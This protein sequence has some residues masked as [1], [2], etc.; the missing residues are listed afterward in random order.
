[1]STI[2][3]FGDSITWGAYDLE[4]GGWVARLKLYFDQKG[5]ET[6]IYN[7]G[8]SGN[9][10]KDVLKRF[11]AEAQARNPDKILFA[12]GI[13]DSPHLAYLFGTKLKDFESRLKELLDK[14]KKYTNDIIILGLTNVDESNKLHGYKN[15][16]IEK[17]DKKLKEIA[18]EQG[19][20]FVDL[21]NI[22]TVD[23]FED[24]L[25]PNS[26]GHQKIFQK[27]KDVLET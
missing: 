2:C 7:L 12:I 23:E 14:A 10:V 20:P 25:H 3:I 9:R 27:V 4:Q 8:V 16:K 15:E 18:Q 6:E 5:G 11:Q 26:K 13:N 21:F 1:M 19:L 22:L 17:Y 24:S